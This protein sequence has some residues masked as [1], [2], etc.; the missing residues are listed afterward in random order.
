MVKAWQ[1]NMNHWLRVGKELCRKYQ[2]HLR[3]LLPT[4]MRIPRN[5]RW[6]EFLKITRS[7]PN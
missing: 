5:Q 3:P 4:I 2:D 6:K 7:I 1:M